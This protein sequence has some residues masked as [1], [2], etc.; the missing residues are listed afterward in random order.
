MSMLDHGLRV[1]KMALEVRAFAFLAAGCELGVETPCSC[2]VVDS[3]IS[4]RVLRHCLCCR[5]WLVRKLILRA[6]SPS[7]FRS[8]P[9]AQ[10]MCLPVSSVNTCRARWVSSSLSKIGRAHV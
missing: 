2:P 6:Q 10:P 3:F 7:S 9:E 4:Q 8:L 5:V 1:P